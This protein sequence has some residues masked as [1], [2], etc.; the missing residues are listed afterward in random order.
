MKDG[1]GESAKTKKKRGGVENGNE[2]EM[3]EQVERK[4]EEEKERVR[5]KVGEEGRGVRRGREA[6]GSQGLRARASC[7]A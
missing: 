6:G 3:H 5:R 7:P 1:G 4:K 2:H